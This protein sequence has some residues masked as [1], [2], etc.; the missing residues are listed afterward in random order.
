VGVLRLIVAVVLALS[1]LALVLVGAFM[2][3]D[4]PLAMIAGGLVA[5]AAG[6]LMET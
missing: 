3:G 2:L 4:L 5:L 6:L 1:G